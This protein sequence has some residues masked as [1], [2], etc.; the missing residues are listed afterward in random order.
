MAGGKLTARQKMINLMYLVFI[1]YIAMTTG[2][3]ILN[4]FSLFN[5]KF[6]NANVLA[7]KSNN[8][9]L[10]FLEKQAS[11]KADT[12]GK[13]YQQAKDIDKISN[14][15]VEYLETQ[16][17]MFLEIGKH[18]EDFKEEGELPA[19]QMDKGDSLDEYW[20]TGDR[21]TKEGQ[22]F[23]ARI[24]KY[25]DD[26]KGILGSD[27]RF[28]AFIDT[29]DER[30]NLNETKNSEDKTV[31]YLDYNFKG[32]P[33]VASYAKITAMQ[34][35]VKNSATD[36]YNVFLGNTVSE[37]TSLKN[38]TAIVIPTK[39]AYFTGESFTGKVV[40]GKY[41]RV[42]PNKLTIGSTELDLKREGAFDSKGA[43]M[44]NFRVGN[45]GEHTFDGKF[46]FVEGGE[47]YD[48]DYSGNYVV[49][50]KPNSATISA[51]KMNVVYRGVDNPMTIS[52]AGVSDNK[53]KATA[54]GLRPAEGTGKYVMK[55]QGGKEVMI[56]VSA[57]LDD[58]Q[59]V[60]DS[61]KYRI[62]DL[63]KPIGKCVGQSDFAR[64]PRNNIEIGKITADFGPDFDFSLPLTV[65][66][67]K[68]KV[69]GKPTVNVSGNRL[70]AQAKNALRTARRGDTVQIFD[71]KVNPPSRSNVTIKPAVGVSIE[72]SN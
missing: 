42:K 60:R 46:T 4:A 8:E 69:P 57:T 18:A 38:Y 48:I 70:N 41:A 32:Y 39:N 33:L 49:V 34:N 55:P 71:I 6:E 10:G 29:F 5:D 53:V 40:I 64:L 19:E 66:S 11:E 37:E 51:D 21:E 43:A 45:V 2:K 24:Q 15:F 35:D 67:F 61:K 62:K 26:L 13:I 44:I 63:P 59:V 25:K 1:A 30:F 7:T 20:F 22:A 17:A 23:V 65:R 52:F 72:L 3:E 16:K 56:S 50:P 28:N 68:F 47:N 54:P 9:L 36:L 31:S 58:G 27:T 12:Y 14:D